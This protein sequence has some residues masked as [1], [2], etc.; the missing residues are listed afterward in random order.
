MEGDL[1]MKYFHHFVN[2]RHLHN[3]ILSM[4]D[5]E[6]VVLI[7]PSSFQHHIVSHFEK[8]LAADPATIRLVA[9]EIRAVVVRFLDVN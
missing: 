6:S 3:R 4:T 7:D 2:K 9:E 1:N 5:D 8:L